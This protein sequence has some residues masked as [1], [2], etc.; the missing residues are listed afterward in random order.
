MS[1]VIEPLGS[2]ETLGIFKSMHPTAKVLGDFKGKD[3]LKL[4]VYTGL[5][6]NSMQL[7]SVSYDFK[8]N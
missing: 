6:G 4:R 7:H 1:G 3:I 2:E 5:R 8:G